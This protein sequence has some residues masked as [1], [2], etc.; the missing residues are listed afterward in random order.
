MILFTEE[1]LLWVHTA[2]Y[3]GFENI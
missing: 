3:S 1:L 2:E